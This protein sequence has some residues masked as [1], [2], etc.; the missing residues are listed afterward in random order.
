[1]G[2]VHPDLLE[3]FEINQEV[4]YAELNWDVILRKVHLEVKFEELS[5]YP[6]VRRDLALVVDLSVRFEHIRS[7]AFVVERKLLKS[8]N[9]FDVYMSDKLGEG[10]KSLAVSFILQDETKTLT[11]KQIEQVMEKL[12]TAF[13]KKLGAVLR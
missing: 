1:M 5:K 12:I 4:W 8:V 3:P 9:I 11:D 7:L 2:Q 6:W 13:E 10:K